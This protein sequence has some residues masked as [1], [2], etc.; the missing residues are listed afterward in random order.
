M[1]HY[2]SSNRLS[3]RC[4]SDVFSENGHVITV[5]S[6]PV[7]DVGTPDQPV[8]HESVSSDESV[9]ADFIRIAP[10]SDE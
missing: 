2:S 3:K 7:G 9:A 8:S 4:Q 1:R 10:R 6:E 5:L